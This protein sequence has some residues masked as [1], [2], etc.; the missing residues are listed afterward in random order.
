MRSY[1]KITGF[2]TLLFFSEFSTAIGL[3]DADL[4]SHFGTPLDLTIPVHHLGDLTGEDLR[5]AL[6]ALNDDVSGHP[7]DALVGSKY[8]I[9][10]D[11]TSNTI[12]L[13]SDEPVM[14]PYL[15]FTLNVRWP[16]GF[17]QREYTVLLDFPA[18]QRAPTT[19]RVA[20]ARQIAQP[21]AQ[22]STPAEARAKNTSAT[23]ETAAHR[24]AAN[25]PVKPA[26]AQTS[27]KQDSLN[28]RPTAQAIDDFAD[29][30][31]RVARGD[32]LWGLA[33]KLSTQREGSHAQWMATVFQENP[34]AFIA[35]QPHRL[36]EAY[37]LAIPENC[38]DTRLVL[39]NNGSGYRLIGGNDDEG[40]SQLATTT[41]EP[42]P[43]AQA[44][45]APS[46]APSTPNSQISS[47]ESAPVYEYNGKDFV[48]DPQAETPSEGLSPY[49]LYSLTETEQAAVEV[50]PVEA[51]ESPLPKTEGEA[52]ASTITEQRIEELERQLDVA[53]ALIEK[54]S[55]QAKLPTPVQPII[56]NSSPALAE[57]TTPAYLFRSMGWLAFGMSVVMGYFMYR[58]RGGPR[59]TFASR[60]RRQRKDFASM[61]QRNS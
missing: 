29:G 16:R 28:P 38:S 36:K 8:Q 61:L 1:L 43:V 45:T 37:L 57:L 51:T 54:Q 48:S 4:R 39:Q 26:R 7:L 47:V 44:E 20:T 22:R 9:D 21:Q 3:G 6:S 32:S 10:Y 15:A 50:T 2:A 25:D 53:L 33:D 42:A 24:T 30:E 35:N 11:E 46:E 60:P 59:L 52:A 49:E 12:R 19:E 18:I 58:D 5:I 31:Y 34:R 17:L 56:S 14:E 41:P 13:R 27:L 55:S 23:S 40:T